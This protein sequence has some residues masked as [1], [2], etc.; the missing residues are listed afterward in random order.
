MLFGCCLTVAELRQ[1]VEEQASI[2]QKTL[3][4]DRLS[5]ISSAK[6]TARSIAW[7][8]LV[9]GCGCMLFGCSAV[10]AGCWLLAAGCWLQAFNWLQAFGCWRLHA[11]WLLAV[12]AGCWLLA[13]LAAGCRLLTGCRLQAVVAPNVWLLAAGC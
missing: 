4:A 10:A 7:R 13:R 2:L 6:R 8:S 5:H 9:A 11:V 12:A 1:G 3:Q